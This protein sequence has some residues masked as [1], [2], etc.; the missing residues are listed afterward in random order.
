MRNRLLALPLGTLAAAVGSGLLWALAFSS[1]APEPVGPWLSWLAL[2]PLLLA[3]R[4]GSFGLGS[5]GLGWVFGVVFWMASIHWIAPTL[6]RFGGLPAPAGWFLLLLLASYLALFSGSFAWAT[7]R[8]IRI[9]APISTPLA[10]VAVPAVWVLAELA[11]GWLFSGFP[12]NPA[13]QAW[14]D[15]PGALPLAAWIGT[16]GVSWLVI[17]IPTAVVV[18]LRT[19]SLR[20]AAVAVLSVA[21]LL[22]VADRW[23]TPASASSGRVPQVPVSAAIVQPN[24]E[25]FTDFERQEVEV[26]YRATL[27]LLRRACTP[28]GLVVVPESAAFPYS[29]S[30]HERL[31][32][33]IN[34][35]AER[36]CTLVLNSTRPDGEEVYNTALMVEGRGV[37]GSYDKV[38]L[39]PWGE[40]VPLKNVLPFMRRIARG[41]SE[42]AA[43]DDV[44]GF[45]YGRGEAGV[46][47]CYDAI[48]AGQTRALVD[49]GA[50]LLVHITNDAWY[51]DTS[52]PRQLLRASRFR[53]AESG[54]W[55][56]RAALTGI[57]AMID[58]AGRVTQ[59]IDFG[60]S[61]IVRGDVP[62]LGAS[63]LYQRLPWL[64]PAAAIAVLAFAI[65]AL[66]G[67]RGGVRSAGD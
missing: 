48:Y 49:A 60:A 39:V 30:I 63:T 53:A 4:A 10:V 38:H 64:V 21:L 19:L 67:R 29:Y 41:A 16:P 25:L 8:L 46:S 7:H 40:Y 62:M 22:A 55:V 17:L 54:R 65:V 61:G 18:S 47:I 50:T 28:G 24:A 44:D 45:T 6:V 57:S 27:D 34:H 2:V 37:T 11:Q 33:D 5:F 52:A 32:E 43:G 12:W 35:L 26:Q 59:R 56:L 1:W 66:R 14:T 42:F 36:G 31:A 3:L 58:P 20:P 13:A 51:G 9:S 15:L 23:A